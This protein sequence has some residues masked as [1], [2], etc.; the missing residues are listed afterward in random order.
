VLI[1]PIGPG[2]QTRFPCRNHSNFGCGEKTIRKNQDKYQ[3]EVKKH[4][5]SNTPNPNLKN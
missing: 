3:K 5:N 4:K 2:L 1:S